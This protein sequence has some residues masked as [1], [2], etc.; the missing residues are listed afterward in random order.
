MRILEINVLLVLAVAVLGWAATRALC[1]SAPPVETSARADTFASGAGH[2]AEQ[3][4]NV[5]NLDR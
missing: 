4:D 5:P 3:M 1:G 2:A